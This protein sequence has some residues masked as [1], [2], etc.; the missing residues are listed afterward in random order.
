MTHYPK[1]FLNK[2]RM[3]AL[4]VMYTTQK[5]VLSSNYWHFGGNRLLLLTKNALMKSDKKLA[6]ALPSPSFEQNKKSSIFFG[7]PFLI[8][9]NLIRHPLK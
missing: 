1:F 6:R 7:T 2:G 9:V 8:S 3:L 5:T 4:W